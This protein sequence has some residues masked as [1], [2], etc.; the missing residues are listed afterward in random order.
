[1]SD[2]WKLPWDGGCLCGQ[3]RFRVSAPPLRIAVC[4]CVWYQKRSASAYSLTIT[5]PADGFA[6]TQGEPELGKGPSP[7]PHFF[8]P[9]ARTGS[10][11][12][13]STLTVPIGPGGGEVQKCA[14]FLR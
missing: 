5:V 7:N 11:G 3:I 8:C 9:C 10:T 2:D 1:M 6:L 12:E 13:N 4:H 14:D